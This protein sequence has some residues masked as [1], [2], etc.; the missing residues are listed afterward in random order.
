MQKNQ[1]GFFASFWFKEFPRKTFLVCRVALIQSIN[2]QLQT[3]TAISPIDGRYRGKLDHLDA[4]FSEYALIKY[5]VEVEIAYFLF[6]AEEKFFK[7]TPSVKKVVIPFNIKRLANVVAERGSIRL[8]WRK[9]T[10]HTISSTTNLSKR[11]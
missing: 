6:L 9:G 2:M 8:F 4:Y 7:I 5:R 1:E 10:I 3:L 11:K